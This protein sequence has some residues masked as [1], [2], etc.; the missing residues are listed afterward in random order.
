MSL[1]GKPQSL[2]W[3]PTGE[4]FCGSVCSNEFEK[5]IESQ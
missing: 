5:G 1:C 3:K 2:Y 4:V